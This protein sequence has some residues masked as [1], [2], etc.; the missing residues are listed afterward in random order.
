MTFTYPLFTEKMLRTQEYVRDI[1]EAQVS[2][3]FIR[4][5][6]PITSWPFG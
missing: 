2:R 1:F 4:K 6:I 5:K 3:S